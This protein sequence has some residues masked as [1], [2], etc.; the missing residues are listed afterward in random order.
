MK[1]EL[2]HLTLFLL[3]AVAALFTLGIL[4]LV[5]C[6]GL[7]INPFRRN[8]THFLLA[9]FG[10]L[11]GLSAILVLLNVATNISIIADSKI[12]NP[13]LVPQSEIFM[14]WIPGFVAA[15]AVIV[16]AIFASTKLSRHKYLLTVR[17]SAEQVVRENEDLL[18]QISQKLASGQPEDYKSA[19]NI[20]EFLG[21]QR[22]GLP[23]LKVVYCGKFQDKLAFYLLESSI[24]WHLR[25]PDSFT[26]Q[27]YACTPNVD[28][29]YLNQFFS[30]GTSEI[31]QRNTGE[32]FSIYVPFIGKEAR[33]VLLF[34]H[35]NRYG[36]IGS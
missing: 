28:C 23:E 33:F 30:G 32:D 18:E 16:T 7:R 19:W 3:T 35:K 34:S 12:A 24:H 36:K 31:L 6:A 10:G 5:M 13:D 27:Y 22:A 2:A 1:L 15:A 14:R 17:Q 11:I 29:E 25:D 4:V 8:T 26:S 20:R 21:K 9:F